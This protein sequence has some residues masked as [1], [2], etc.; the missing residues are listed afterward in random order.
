MGGTNPEASLARTKEQDKIVQG[1][2]V[3]SLM[4]ELVGAQKKNRFSTHFKGFQS[5]PGFQTIPGGFKPIYSN[6]TENH[7]K[8]AAEEEKQ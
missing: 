3:T 5:T 2:V 7:P 4:K 8:P 6:K 1:N